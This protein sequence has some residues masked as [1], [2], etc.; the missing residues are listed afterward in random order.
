VCLILPVMA[1][2]YS[3]DGGKVYLINFDDIVHGVSADFVIEGIEKANADKA[4]LI[5]I[6]MQTPGGMVTSMEKMIQKILASKV[7]VV[8]FVNPSGAKAASAGFYILMACDVAV[9]AP[10]TRTGAATPIM[11]G[12][13]GDS[14]DE[15]FK[16]LME[17]V[18]GDSR[19]FLRTLVRGHLRNPDVPMDFTVEKAVETIDKSDAY[20][21]KEAMEYGLI[22]F[23]ASDIDEIL[24]KL[25]GTEIRRF[26][27][28]GEEPTFTA[29]ST[30]DAIVEQVEMD[31]RQQFLSYLS[32]PMIAMILGALGIFGLYIEFN[33]PGMIFPGA[34]GVICLVLAAISFQIL[35][36]NWA[37][38]ILIL[39]AVVLFILEFSIASYGM[40]TVGGIICLVIGGLMLFEGPIPELRLNL[41]Q[42]IPFALAFAGISLFL[43]RLV[44]KA[45]MGKVSTGYKGLVG[46][47]G[48]VKN[49]KAYLHGEIWSIANKEEL[50]EG[51]DIEVTEMKGLSLIVKK[52]N[53]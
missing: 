17:K 45:H 26:T 24:A 39:I 37:G 5:I 47:K 35:T 8:G 19:A 11:M 16:T 34:V 20:T 31:F 51:D 21:E 28:E 7:P 23:T 2:F 12:G 41:W 46:A 10:G 30:A 1:G 13:G 6:S 3:E 36:V 27:L 14:E 22:N 43:L 33:N 15:N 18:K 25:D 50:A 53:S 38:L 49:G 9:M 42:M 44:I 32:N 48:T 52:V 40:L 4:E 29:V